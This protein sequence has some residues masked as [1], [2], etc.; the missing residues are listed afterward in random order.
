VVFGGQKE[1]EQSTPRA[2]GAAYASDPSKSSATAIAA[3]AP[4]GITTS[5]TWWMS[6]ADQNIGPVH[7]PFS[8]CP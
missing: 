7:M 5:G 8:I 3:V 1:G 6:S 2:A 4:L